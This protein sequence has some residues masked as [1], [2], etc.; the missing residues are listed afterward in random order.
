MSDDLRT[1]MI[2]AEGRL[3]QSLTT[4]PRL[5]AAREVVV[6]VVPMAIPPVDCASIRATG[7][8]FRS[9]SR[10]EMLREHLHLV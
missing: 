9:P 5:A 2:D 10:R 8:G 1:G 7:G 3:L 6:R 4:H